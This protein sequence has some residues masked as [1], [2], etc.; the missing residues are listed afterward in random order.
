MTST[1]EL[2]MLTSLRVTEFLDETAANSPAP[3][4]GSVAALA[5]SLGAALTSMV[6]RLTIGKKKYI[7]VQTEMD[8]VLKQSEELRAQFTAMID[9]DT[10]A[11]NN[12]MTAFA[13]PKDTDEQK[14][15]RSAAIQDA[16]KAAT[17]VPLKLLELCTESIRLVKIVA[18][19]GNQNSLSDAGVAAWMIRAGS[20]GA[21]L[22]ININLA[23]LQD[24]AFK[25]HIQKQTQQLLQQTQVEADSILKR[26]NNL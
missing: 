6:C 14:T 8:S 26:V 3:G 1:K 12:V 20:E 5:A 11:F 19:K 9:E 22:N 16:T 2:L 7:D 18:E 17:L 10:T 25:E 15:V 23:G 21:V 13:L 24:A 4:G